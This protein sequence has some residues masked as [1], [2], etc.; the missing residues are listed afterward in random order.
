M[1]LVKTKI[2]P[3]KIHGIGLFADQFIAK[4]TP[5]WK[6]KKGFDL[7]YTKTELDQLS[8]PA[9][10]QFLHYCYS[11][12]DE[13]GHNYVVCADDY[14][15]LNHSASPNITNIEIVGEEEG[16]DIAL[17]DIQVGEELVCDCREF[18]EDCAKDIEA[19]LQP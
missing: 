8:K 1:L 16:V 18:D 15:F 19:G 10:D 17:K 3:S 11:Y 9:R 14:R 5:I 6:F 2:G 13:T 7:K 4:D 12:S